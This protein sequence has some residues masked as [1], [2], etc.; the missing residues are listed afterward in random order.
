M[1]EARLHT[2]E[3]VLAA[4]E[5]AAAREAEKAEAYRLAAQR[6][7]ERVSALAAFRDQKTIPVK[8]PDLI[9]RFLALEALV[10]EEL[11]ARGE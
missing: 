11:E 10:L 5:A 8:L 1:D 6:R 2:I 3:A 7:A 4:G 9:Q